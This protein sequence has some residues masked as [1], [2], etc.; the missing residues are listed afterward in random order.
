[1][2]I[3]RFSPSEARDVEVDVSVD[4]AGADGVLFTL[5]T[6]END[7]NT[8]TNKAR[9]KRDFISFLLHLLPSLV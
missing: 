8:K 5:N 4:T 2:L 3:P 7:T 6:S 9:I 1:M